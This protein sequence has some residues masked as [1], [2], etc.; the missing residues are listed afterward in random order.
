[1][2]SKCNVCAMRIAH[3]ANSH[4]LNGFEPI[5]SQVS[6]VLRRTPHIYSAH[7]L[8]RPDTVFT[9]TAI[10][11]TLLPRFGLFNCSLLI[12]CPCMFEHKLRSNTH[13]VHVTVNTSHELRM[14][15]KMH[16]TELGF[17]VR[18]SYAALKKITLRYIIC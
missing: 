2:R 13:D 8:I 3:C 10:S 16:T 11:A 4:T 6:V 14:R 15:R 7:L 17:L 18:V 12:M 5:F 1:M 9:Q